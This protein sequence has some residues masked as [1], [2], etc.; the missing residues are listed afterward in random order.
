MKVL[1]VTLKDYRNYDHASVEFSNGLNV[2]KGKNAQGKT[3]LLES[4][5]FCAIGKSVRLNKDKD[6]IKWKKD[7]SKVQLVFDSD[8][9][10]KKIEIYIFKNQNKS[11]KINGVHIS[12]MGELMGEF[13]AVYFSP[14]ELKLVKNSPD[15]RRRFMDID[16]SQYNKNYFY[17]LNKYNKILA[18]RNKLLKTGGNDI[19]ETV[20]IWDD[21][22]S[23]CGAYIIVKRMKLIET[24]KQ[25]ANTVNK[26]LTG[27]KEDLQLS[28]TGITGLDE[29]DIAQKIVNDLRKNIEK[30]MSLGYTSVGPHRDDIK[31]ESNGIDIRY[32][33]SQGQQRTCALSLKLA[34]LEFFK[35]AVGSYPV[36]LLDDVLSELDKQ[37]QEK[38]LQ[39]VS[40]Y[41]TIITTTDFPFNIKHSLYEIENGQ[42]KII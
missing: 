25:H 17:N 33:G 6:L 29:Q 38:L 2:I 15:E 41:Q 12:R 31:I 39:F 16:L 26:Y 32:F 7:V 27:E 34:E 42:V 8:K 28:Y 1:N 11:I 9:G 36:L 4:I 3:N 10:K 37:R 18:Q 13:N 19:K 40:K 24:L 23:K 30:D 20:S 14:D 22:L 5:F 21:S 35:E